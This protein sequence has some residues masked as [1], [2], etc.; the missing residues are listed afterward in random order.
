MG[1]CMGDFSPAQ[2]ARHESGI[3]G[4]GCFTG[5]WSPPSQSLWLPAFPDHETG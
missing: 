4:S 1:K 5:R 2:L 3:L